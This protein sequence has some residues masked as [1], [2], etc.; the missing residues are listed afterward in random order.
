MELIS[1]FGGIKVGKKLIC[2]VKNQ[3]KLPFN[4]QS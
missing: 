2:L 4:I 3:Q 1:Y